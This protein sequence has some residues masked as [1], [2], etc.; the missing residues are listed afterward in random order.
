MPAQRRG[1]ARQ[2]GRRTSL[3]L[4][5]EDH[6]TIIKA[7]AFKDDAACTEDERR[8]RLIEYKLCQQSFRH[9]LKWCKVAEPPS[10][11]GGS[12]GIIPFAVWPHTDELIDTFLTKR[13]IVVLKSRQIGLSWLVAL[14][15]LWLVM[16]K[17]AA[18][19]I[20]FSKGEAEASELLSKAAFAF[21]Y[22]P[23][24]LQLK[25]GKDS[26]SKLTFPTMQSSIQV[27]PATKS[28][29]VSFTAS[30]LVYDEWEQHEYAEQSYAN[31]KPVIDAGGQLIGILTRDPFKAAS[32]GRNIFIGGLAGRNGFTAKFFPWTVRPSRNQAW[33]EETMNGL[34]ADELQTLTPELYMKCNYPNSIEEALEPL[35]AASACDQ[36]VLDLMKEDTRT[37]IRV[38]AD[39]LDTK[40]CNIFKDYSTGA[41]YIAA[42]DTS[43][44]VGLDDSATVIIN[45]KTGE[46]VADILDNLLPPEQLA[47]HSVRLLEYFHTPLWFIE[48]NDWGA[49]TIKVAE[50]LKYR[51]FGYQDPDKKTRIGWHTGS[52]RNRDLLW[53]ALI[54][55]IN[56]RQLVIYNARGLAQ[57]RD[58][59][60]NSKKDGRIEAMGGRKD[61][62]PMACGIAYYNRD[63]VHTE[64]KK[65]Q[66]IQTLHFSGQQHDDLLTTMLRPRPA[67]RFN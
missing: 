35:Q 15:S 36:R 30:L 32:L 66:P 19:V 63:Q 62:Y 24:F 23:P 17:E 5:L 47:V 67:R 40:L 64:V 54:P 26:E 1:Q 50:S 42:T 3:T 61:D 56:N 14:Y 53:G 45:V 46:V 21:D 22:L 41:F 7:C 2:Q 28:A 39:G 9:F 12:G 6:D 25:K 48:D 16:F 34:S 52:G 65:W 55:A 38:V 4:T 33:Y 13:L 37:T 29:G 51:N 20:M 18:K 59:I 31:A 60:R 10:L 44:G 58:L 57:F 49:T 8:A 27:L 43:H 11:I